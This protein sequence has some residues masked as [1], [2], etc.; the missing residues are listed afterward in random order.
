[1]GRGPHDPPT[2]F[3]TGQCLSNSRWERASLG[4]LKGDFISRDEQFI[5]LTYNFVGKMLKKYLFC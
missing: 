4:P 2:Y 5:K 3:P 1:V